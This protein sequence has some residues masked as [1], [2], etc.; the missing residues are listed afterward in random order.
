VLG[1]SAYFC[2][3]IHYSHATYLNHGEK[4]TVRFLSAVRPGLDQSNNNAS[5]IAWD[6]VGSWRYYAESVPVHR[7][8][9]PRAVRRRHVVA[10]PA[11]PGLS[12]H[13]KRQRGR[14]RKGRKD[15]QQE[16]TCPYVPYS[17]PSPVSSPPSR[18]E[19][20]L[21]AIY[22]FPPGPILRPTSVVR[23]NSKIS[24]VHHSS[25]NKSQILKRSFPLLVSL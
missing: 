20:C 3:F 12:R 9:R 21:W 17:S 24:R 16:N 10:P 13:K 25:A 2:L 19:S 22:L 1:G 15:R 6:P 23:R 7:P 14:Q 8:L 18:S 4:Q 5:L 11:P